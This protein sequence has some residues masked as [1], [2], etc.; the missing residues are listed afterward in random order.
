MLLYSNLH[1]AVHADKT[2]AVS[3]QA[4]ELSNTISSLIC[5]IVVLL[6]LNLDGCAGNAPRFCVP[7]AIRVRSHNKLYK[8]ESTG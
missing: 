6:P 4:L 2:H 8:K 5:P 1:Y 7:D 3:G